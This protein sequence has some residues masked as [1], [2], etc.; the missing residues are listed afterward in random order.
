MLRI[1]VCLLLAALGLGACGDDAAD[2]APGAGLSGT[3][4]VL[5]ATSL[6]D[7]FEEI[8][9]AFEAEHDGVEVALTFDGSARLAT[10]IVEGSPADV[11]APA[12]AANL[13]KVAE[14]GLLDG[15]GTAFATNELQI[16]VAAGNPLGISGIEDLGDDI[17]LSLCAVEVPCGSYA[18]TAFER[19]GQPV[20]AAGEEENVRGVLS[21]VQL[22]EA[23]AG[24]VYATDVLAADG[25]E[26]VDLAAGEQV[27]VSYP[28]AVLTDAA[29]EA[30]AA[31]F[32]RFLTDR[33]AQAILQGLGFGPP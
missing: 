18:V 17:V 1:A 15:R 5:A 28:A 29:N 16:V 8:A 19:A 9:A 3:L 31:A 32:V 30:V 11:F 2:G 25:V 22:G 4:T 26:G 27:V 6:T 21:R 24:I 33:E 10:A 12:D 13:A 20:P 23:D 14:A 7:A